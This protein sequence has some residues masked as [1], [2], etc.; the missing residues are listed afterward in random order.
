MRCWSTSTWEPKRSETGTEDGERLRLACRVGDARGEVH[1]LAEGVALLEE[2]GRGAACHHRAC[3]RVLVPKPAGKLERMR[4]LLL[5]L[6]LPT[7]D[8]ARRIGRVPR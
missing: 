8:R 3:H 4:D 6:M 2:D 7:L 1:G 5:V